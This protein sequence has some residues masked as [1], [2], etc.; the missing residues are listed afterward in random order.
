MRALTTL[1]L[2]LLAAPALAVTAVAPR[3]A[4]EVDEVTLSDL[5]PGAPAA[6]ARVALG[7]A[8][9]PG[10]ERILSGA[11]V[12]KQA[13]QVGADALLQV[14]EA[15]VLTR[16]AADLGREELIAAVDAALAPRLGAGERAR[17]TAVGLPGPLPAGEVDLEVVLPDGDFPSPTTVVVEVRV[18][19]ER[20]GRGWA[21]VETFRGVPGVVLARAVRRGEVLGAEDLEVRMVDAGRAGLTDAGVAVGKRLTRSLG[22]GAAVAARDLE[23]LPLVGRGDT[24]R[25]VAR[26]GGVTASTLGRVL[27]P[28]GAG[29]PVRVENLSSGRTVA[30][31][32]REAGV[33]DVSPRLGR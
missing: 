6:W 25:L 31:I 14:P 33:V 12:L 22:A 20:R 1:A 30:G 8:P 3:I 18:D 19:G 21:R 9:R 16:A 15:V 28:A 11:W 26:V 2:V 10:G 5:V 7:R 17:V 29:E 23:A 4:V 13:R 24:V 27:E 32:L